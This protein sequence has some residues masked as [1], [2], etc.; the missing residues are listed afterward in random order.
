MIL[1]DEE[2]RSGGR[3][4][5]GSTRRLGRAVRGVDGSVRELL[6]APGDPADLPEH[7]LW[8]VDGHGISELLVVGR[9]DR[10][11]RSDVCSTLSRARFDNGAVRRSVAAWT[12]EQLGKRKVMLVVDE[13]GDEKSSLDAVGAARQ[14]SG[15]LGAR[16]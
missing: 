7:G 6:P 9:G 16:I 14:Y 4:D 13:T 10:P 3:E 11:Q 2:S 5:H 12:V 1:C 8:A 15:A